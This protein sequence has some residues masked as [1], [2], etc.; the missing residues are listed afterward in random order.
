MVMKPTNVYKRWRVCFYY[1]SYTFR[2][3]LWPSLGRLRRIYYKNV[4]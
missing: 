1:A 2:P 3:H 4:L